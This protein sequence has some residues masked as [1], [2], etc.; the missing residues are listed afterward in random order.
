MGQMDRPDVT[1]NSCELSLAESILGPSPTPELVS[2]ARHTVFQWQA[3]GGRIVTKR[4]A[5]D[6]AYEAEFRALTWLEHSSATATVLAREAP[7][8]AM[9]FL[10]GDR[11]LTTSLSP[12]ASRDRCSTPR[13]R[14]PEFTMPAPTFVRPTSGIRHGAAFRDL[15]AF[16]ITTPFPTICLSRTHA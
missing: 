9:S 13:P 11:S 15:K 4:Y 10:T 14:S 5:T 8:I 6:D 12:R 1:P 3:P 2:A 16:A 7:V